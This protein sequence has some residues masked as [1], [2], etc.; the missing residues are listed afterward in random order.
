[1]QTR[2]VRRTPVP[3]LEQSA[4][5]SLHVQAASKDHAASQLHTTAHV[6]PQPPT[7]INIYMQVVCDS[8]QTAH[9]LITAIT[10]QK[11]YARWRNTPAAMFNQV[12]R[13]QLAQHECAAAQY[14]KP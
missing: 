11:C 3:A 4:H 14:V 1:M 8:M 9:G 12:Q 7:H 13:Q 6:H 10:D 5:V 2:G